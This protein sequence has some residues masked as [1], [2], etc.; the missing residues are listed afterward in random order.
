M[1]GGMSLIDLVKVAAA[2][3]GGL[4][5]VYLAMIGVCYLI[6]KAKGVL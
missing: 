2:C 1:M 3:A 6:G 5:V 4:G